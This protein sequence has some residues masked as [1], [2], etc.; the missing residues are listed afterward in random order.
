[1]SNARLVMGDVLRVLE[2]GD[3]AFVSLNTDFCFEQG[4]LPKRQAGVLTASLAKGGAGW[5]IAG[6]SFGGGAPV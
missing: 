4:A 2:T 6:F 3:H 1:M 5:R